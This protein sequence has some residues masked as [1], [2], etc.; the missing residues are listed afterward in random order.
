MKFKLLVSD[1]WKSK[2]GGIPLGC[3]LLAFHTDYQ[4]DDNQT[5]Q[6]ALLLRALEPID[7]PNN[8]DNVASM[9][10]YYK[11]SQSVSNADQAEQASDRRY[12]NRN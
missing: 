3:F 6:T 4:S 5:P 11:E 2:A 7:L 10:E 1:D 8:N 9:L 12:R